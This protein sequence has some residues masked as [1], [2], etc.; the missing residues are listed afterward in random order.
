MWTATAPSCAF[1]PL[2]IFPV[3]QYAVETVSHVCPEEAE[4]GEVV[5]TVV[6]LVST[7]TVESG[8]GGLALLDRAARTV[9]GV[10]R[11]V[12]VGCMVVVDVVVV[13]EAALALKAASTSGERV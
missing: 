6:G 12:V 8:G 2:A 10:S 3:R 9:E 13:A 11:W 7:G 1:S 5:A 4:G